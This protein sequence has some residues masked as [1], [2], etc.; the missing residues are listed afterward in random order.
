M[1]AAVILINPLR[2]EFEVEQGATSVLKHIYLQL[3]TGAP[4]VGHVKGDFTVAD[5][6][7]FHYFRSDASAVVDAK[8]TAD[9]SA[10]ALTSGGTLGTWVTSQFIEVD[11]TNMPGWYE[12]G[13]PDAAFAE[14]AEENLSVTFTIQPDDT[15]A[16]RVATV[17]IRLKA[18]EQPR[19]VHQY[20]VPENSTSVLVDIYIE[21]NRGTPAVGLTKTEFEVSKESQFAYHRSDGTAAVDAAFDGTDTI[22]DTSTLG[23]WITSSLKEISSSLMPGWYELGLPDAALVESAEGNA[24][25]S[26]HI[27]GDLDAGIQDVRLEVRMTGGASGGSGSSAA[28]EV[29][30]VEKANAVNVRRN[31]YLTNSATGLAATG[32]T[33]TDFTVANGAEFAYYR[34]DAAAAVDAK[35]DGTTALGDATTLGT[36]ESATI[37]EISSALMPGWYEIGFPNSLFIINQ[38]SGVKARNVTCLIKPEDDSSVSPV[39]LRFDLLRSIAR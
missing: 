9:A 22:G 39:N 17:H 27:K 35:F 6:G 29:R 26:F 1:A 30:L 8:S 31:V 2:Y 25:C 23:T 4:A 15:S 24:K 20:V 19:V 36:W 13:F 7:R 21:T 34:G 12:V 3:D 33:K 5:G 16:S 11:A 32:L 18:K 28:A 38:A 37:K 14:S 10:N